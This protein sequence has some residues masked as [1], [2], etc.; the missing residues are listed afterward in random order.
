MNINEKITDQNTLIST[1]IELYPSWLLVVD[2]VTSISS[3]HVHLPQPGIEQ[4][5]RGQLLITTQDIVSIPLK[6]S[7]IDHISISEG[8]DPHEAIPY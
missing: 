6:S 8:M 1:Q 4:W 5:I 7:F 3:V 2:N